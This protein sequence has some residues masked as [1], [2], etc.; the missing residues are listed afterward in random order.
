MHNEAGQGIYFPFTGCTSTSVRTK[1]V[2][3]AYRRYTLLSF[4][5]F[6]AGGNQHIPIER[7][8]ERGNWDWLLHW[9]LWLLF[10]FIPRNK[11]ML[12]QFVPNRLN[13]IVK[14]SLSSC[15]CCTSSDFGT[16]C[17]FILYIQLAFPPVNLRFEL[18]T[19]ILRKYQENAI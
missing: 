2:A 8:R 13:S 3:Q 17:Y 9:I 19:R 16:Y 4:C 6:C 15:S 14:I 5:V 11:R 1:K 7:E 12:N 18:V 10:Y